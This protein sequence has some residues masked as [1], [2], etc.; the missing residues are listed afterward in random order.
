M[1]ILGILIIINSLVVTGYW[2]SG[3]HQHK[4]WVMFICFL[5][6]FV[7]MFFTLHGRAIEI[8]LPKIGSIKAAAEQVTADANEVSEIK[9]RIKAQSATIDLIAKEATD[10]KR[11]VEDLSRKNSEAEEKLSKLDKSIQ[12]GNRAVKEL[13]GYT[14]FNSTVLAA[15]NDDRQAYDQLWT[16]SEDTSFPFQR[17]AA[18]AV[19]TVMD[20]HNPAM[21][22][23]GFT[24]SW[25][26]GVDPQKLT[27]PELWQAYKG[28][29]AH[30]RIGILEFLWEKRTDISKK[31]RLQ[32]LTDVLRSDE[33]LRVIEYAGRYFAQGTDDKLK[34]I[35]IDPHLKWWEENKDSIE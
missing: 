3:E 16:W 25:N 6:V 13:Q 7:G 19:Q 14:Q 15:Q 2:I 17:A 33:S 32:F 12:D 11:L 30:I 34:P 21:V 4:G 9:E 29:P 27:L 26:E 18:R 24:V 35:A 8:I 23:G 1:K 20:Q 31:N 28:A 5:A 10:A 22:R